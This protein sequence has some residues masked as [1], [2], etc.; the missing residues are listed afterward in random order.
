VKNWKRRY[1]ILR[2]SRLEYFEEEGT[3]LKG[4]MNLG[5]N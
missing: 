5:E 1:C 4:V 3:V 2:E